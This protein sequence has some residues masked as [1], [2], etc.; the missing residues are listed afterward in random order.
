MKHDH[1]PVCGQ[2]VP[3]QDLLQRLRDESRSA[4]EALDQS[5]LPFQKNPAEHLKPFL[6]AQMAGLTALSTAVRTSP[7]RETLGLISEMLDRLEQDCRHYGL[8]VP[9]VRHKRELHPV[10]LSYLVIGSRLGTEVL[11]R[12]LME[13]ELDHVPLYFAPQEYK[14]IW[15]ELCL[16]LGAMPAIGAEA[17]DICTSV[18]AGFELFQEAET[19]TRDLTEKSL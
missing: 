6:A 17:E 1:G 5:F 4:H 18:I 7:D 15:R 13:S 2:L 9:V 3:K 16:R 19:L 10:A 14:A 12:K 11:R 8:S